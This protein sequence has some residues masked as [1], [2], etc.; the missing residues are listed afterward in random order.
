MKTLTYLIKGFGFVDIEDFKTS[1]FKIFYVDKS[2]WYLL[3][4]AI[5]GTIRNF[6]ETSTG[7]DIAVYGALVFLISAEVQSGVKVSIV[8]KNER[9][10]SRKIGRMILKIGIYSS[11]LYVLYTFATGFP[12]PSVLG[13]EVNPFQWLY[14]VVFTGIVFQLVISWLENL[15]SLGYNEA[16]GIVGVILRKYNQWFE[17]DGTKNADKI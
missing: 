8:K 13:F 3:L 9:I 7:L 17:F 11:I 2:S 15:A 10:Q 4:T 12:A 1:V 14:Y 6:I 16:R 5:L